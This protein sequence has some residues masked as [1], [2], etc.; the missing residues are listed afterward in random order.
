[1][2]LQDRVAVITGAGRGVG[3]ATA[4]ALAR[5]ACSLLVNY[6]RS[7][8]EAE[9]TTEEIRALGVKAICF[10]ADVADDKACR[11]MM[12]AA[13][14]EFGRLDILVNNAGTTEFINH[15]QLDAFDDKHWDRLLAVNLKGPFFCARAARP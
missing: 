9:A 10:Q 13:A 6:G 3:R 2:N 5:G 12:A 8:D 7:R 15:A 1:M 4:L 14:R 11:A